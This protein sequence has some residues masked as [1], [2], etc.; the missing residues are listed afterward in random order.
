MAYMYVYKHKNIHSCVQD[1]DRMIHAVSSCV[2]N[3]S[4]SVYVLMSLLASA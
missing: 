1:M 3:V 2:S 4:G